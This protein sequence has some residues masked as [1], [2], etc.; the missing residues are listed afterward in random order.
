M[1]F[2]R[3]L[4]VALIALMA[5]NGFSDTAKKTL[6]VV[7]TDN[8]NGTGT[9]WVQAVEPLSKNSGFQGT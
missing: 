8:K 3:L 1:S 5:S 4:F 6:K 9:Q 2:K 7:Y